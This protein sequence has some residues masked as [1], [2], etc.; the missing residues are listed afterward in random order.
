MYFITL[1]ENKVKETEEILN[2]RIEKMELNIREIQAIE[3][4][5]VVK[6]KVTKAYEII[7]KPVMVEDTGLYINSWNGFPGALIKW[8]LESI[9]NEKLCKL[10]DR[11]RSAIAKT[12]IAIFNGRKLYIFSGELKGNITEKP[13]GNGFGWDPIF[14]PDGYDKTFGEMPREEKNKISM[15]RIALM[16]LKKFLE[17]NENFFNI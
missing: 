2:I 4:E 16:K 12:C 13:R 8:V 7:K 1:N 15:R 11:D 5:E 10:L 9:G 3:V 14:Q 17:E 6:D